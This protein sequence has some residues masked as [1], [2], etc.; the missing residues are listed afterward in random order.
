[1]AS[2]FLE[3]RGFGVLMLPLHGFVVTLI[4]D[5]GKTASGGPKK[6]IGWDETWD[7]IIEESKCHLT[8]S[9]AV[10]VQYDSDHFGVTMTVDYE[11]TEQRKVEAKGARRQL[12][13]I[14][15]PIICIARK[16]IAA[17]KVREFCSSWS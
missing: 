10:A 9:F 13:G 2:K 16:L 12:R 15:P 14:S 1:M 7:M 5:C 6:I 17:T 11:W 3:E 4:H 8:G